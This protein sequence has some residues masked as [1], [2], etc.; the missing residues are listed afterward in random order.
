MRP[1]VLNFTDLC[2]AWDCLRLTKVVLARWWCWVSGELITSRARW[3]LNM[4]LSQGQPEKRGSSYRHKA[5]GKTVST[6]T[7]S[8]GRSLASFH[9]VREGCDQSS[10]NTREN[11]LEMVTKVR[12]NPAVIARTKAVVDVIIAVFVSLDARDQIIWYF[13]NLILGTLSGRVKA[14]TKGTP[15]RVFP[16]CRT[17][18]KLMSKLMSKVTTF[19]FLL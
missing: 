17:M 8:G 13:D 6:L 11:V 2:C 18:S 10:V 3:H 12:D 5:W 7:I 9:P 4:P 19:T 16:L 15:E 1:H 14:G